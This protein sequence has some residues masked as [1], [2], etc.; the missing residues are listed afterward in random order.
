MKEI[1][2][3]DD[4]KKTSWSFASICVTLGSSMIASAL[5]DDLCP[6]SG[7]KLK[8]IDYVTTATFL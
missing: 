7:K 6:K 3:W 8:F 4:A 2:E 1:N 5:K